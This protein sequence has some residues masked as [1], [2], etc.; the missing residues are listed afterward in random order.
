MKT[1]GLQIAVYVLLGLIIGFLLNDCRRQDDEEV[2]TR[3]ETVF[4]TDTIYVNKI[5]TVYITKAKIVHEFV[6]DTVMENYTPTINSYSTHFPVTYGS[7]FINGE[8]LGEVLNMKATTHLKIPTVTN[9]ITHTVT[10]TVVKKPI[11]LYITA[12]L[13]QSLVP[14]IGGVFV[15]DKFLV[16]YQYNFDQH[17]IFIGK[18]I[19]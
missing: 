18:K 6:R 16:G 5:D 15:K 3:V 7:V 13:E 1:S 4:K 2:I 14:N 10:N 9:T 19:F 11:G 8:V 12:G 17:S